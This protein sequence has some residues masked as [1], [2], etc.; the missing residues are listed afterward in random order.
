MR[1]TSSRRTL[2]HLIVA[3]L[4]LAAT[5]TLCSL[6]APSQAQTATTLI[7][8]GTIGG[9]TGN[10]T[11]LLFGYTDAQRG[12]ATGVNYAQGFGV[13]GDGTTL[14]GAAGTPSGFAH[15]FAWTA[16]GGVI[17]LGSLGGASSAS[18]ATA[19]S[20]NGSVVVGFSQTDASGTFEHAFM[21]SAGTGMVDLAV[22]GGTTLKGN[23]IATGVSAD[24]K[25]IVGAYVSGHEQAFRW[26][27]GSGV[28]SLS[29]I[30]SAGFLSSYGLYDGLGVSADGNVVVG[31]MQTNGLS[32]TNP[33]VNAYRWTGA[34]GLE[35]L[36]TLN[37]VAGS[38]VASAANSDG[39]V[40]VG[41]S[42]YD[43]ALTGFHA[44]RWSAAD[45]MIDL[46]TLGNFTGQSYATAVNTDG[47]IVVGTSQIATDNT[48]GRAFVWTS[49]TGM[50]DLNTL[51]ASG[52]VNMTGVTLTA[53]RG[54]SSSGA[55][56]VGDGIFPGSGLSTHAYI[57]RIGTGSGGSSGGGTGGGSTGGGGTSGGG[58]GGSSG[59]GTGGSSGGVGGIVGVTTPQSVVAS[60]VQLSKSLTAQM[61]NNAVLASVLLGVNEQLSCAN[62]GGG[63]MSIGSF[64]VGTHG[65]RELTDELTA[66][67]GISYGQYKEEDANVS[68]AWTLA[69]SL[70]F[71][72]QGFG[73]SRPFVEAGVT[74]SPAQ[75]VT[76]R[77]SYVNGA[78]TATGIGETRT[79]DYSAFARVG[80]ID[81][82]TRVDE[83]GAYAQ[84]TRSWQTVDAY[85]EAANSGNPFEASVPGGTTTQ[86]ALGVGAQYTHLFGRYTE[87]NLN[88]GVAHAFGA[89]SSLSATVAGYGDVQTTP[90]HL[91][92]E[93]VGG[94]IGRR[95]GKR[96]TIDLFADA[97][98]G[99]HQIGNSVHGGFDFNIRF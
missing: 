22:S 35:V 40:V 67:G 89:A 82:L 9:F 85:T 43:A 83:I 96:V 97:A 66:L 26:T 75:Q 52:G 93:T 94:R 3:P 55:F 34:S 2:P 53:A 78:G 47:S 27:Q 73:A 31:W 4:M 60:I 7:D 28:V 15:A 74:V 81:R 30:N 49:Q 39:S 63:Y 92:W 90:P 17:D 12:T 87:F 69:G 48:N 29:S 86:A 54:I 38:S 70:R 36:G 77:R 61:I 68:S 8:P 84:F 65:R 50:V 95:I 13:S 79:G 37:K 88:A 24:G 42:N 44:F 19:T 45:G 98:L 51:M 62:C 76:Y 91:T 1:T 58:T 64:T 71:D 14:V 11:Y 41:A 20:G 6:P 46:G 25:V 59:G 80:W 32:G 33:I 16:S 99:A 10:V 5:M 57:A 72:P 56:V 21:W 23:S 18:I